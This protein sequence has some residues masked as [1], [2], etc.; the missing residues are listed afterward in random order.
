MTHSSLRHIIKPHELETDVQAYKALQVN[1][2]YYKVV[3]NSLDL[4]TFSYMCRK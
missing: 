2:N 4:K 1:I 3:C